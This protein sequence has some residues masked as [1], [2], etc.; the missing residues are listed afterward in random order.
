[1]STDMASE[2]QEKSSKSPEKESTDLDTQGIVLKYKIPKLKLV[3]YYLA[4]VEKDIVKS[5]Y[6]GQKM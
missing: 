5:I 1:M 6:D 3:K 4:L 2:S